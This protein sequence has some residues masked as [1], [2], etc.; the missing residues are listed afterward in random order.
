VGRDKPPYRQNRLKGHSENGGKRKGIRYGKEQC[1]LPLQK[2]GG[3][4]QSI[5]G[6]VVGLTDVPL[7]GNMGVV[8]MDRSKGGSD[9]NFSS[10]KGIGATAKNRYG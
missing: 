7:E 2:E 5:R 3:N 10:R 8:G 6:G 9:L 4:A 1:D